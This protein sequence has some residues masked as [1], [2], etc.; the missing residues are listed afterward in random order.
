M[1]TD[2][3]SALREL[4]YLIRSRRD[5]LGMNRPT[6]AKNSGVERSDLALLEHQRADEVS[7][8]KIVKVGVR[9]RFRSNDFTNFRNCIQIIHPEYELQLPRQQISTGRQL[10]RY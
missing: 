5:S 1:D 4:A 6:L 8:E 9:L 2:R 10:P 3:Y 7:P